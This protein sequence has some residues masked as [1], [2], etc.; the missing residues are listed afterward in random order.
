MDLNSDNYATSYFSSGIGGDKSV[1]F[2]TN[3]DYNVTS[4]SFHLNYTEPTGNE[5]AIG[6]IYIGSLLHTMSRNP[7]SKNYKPTKAPQQ[8]VHKLSDGGRRIHRLKQNW[9][10]KIKYQII[11]ESERSSLETIFNRD[12]AFYFAAFETDSSW[13]AIFFKSVW[14]GPFDFYEF[15]NDNPNTGNRGSIS[16]REASE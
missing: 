14:D 13:D 15:T 10:A 16:L 3:I 1:Y 5:K 12:E 2:K 11:D 6:F 4:L 7:S 9:S 8:S